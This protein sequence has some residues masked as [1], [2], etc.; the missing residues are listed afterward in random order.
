MTTGNV[1]LN[2]LIWFVFN[3]YDIKTYKCAKRVFLKLE[4][5]QKYQFNTAKCI[6]YLKSTTVLLPDWSLTDKFLRL[7]SKKMFYINLFQF[8][9]L[10]KS[11]FEKNF[12]VIQNN[13]Y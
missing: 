1:K 2:D 11:Y 13:T 12:N 8:Y 7:R 10:M 9:R 6:E 3:V 5:N 4:K